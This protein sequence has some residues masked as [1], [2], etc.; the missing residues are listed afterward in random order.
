MP[1]DSVLS[2]TLGA[3][4]AVAGAIGAVAGVLGKVIF[5]RSKR[6][7]ETIHVKRLEVYPL[8]WKTTE[9]L[10]LWPRSAT[11]TCEKLQGFCENLRDWYFKVGGMFLSER[12]RN[13]YGRL[14]QELTDVLK[15]QPQE[16][17]LPTGELYERLRHRCSTLRTELTEDLSSRR[18]FS[19]TEPRPEN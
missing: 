3:V 12:S 15:S 19:G 2:S 17:L 13:A 4:G 7:D 6:A 18:R 9:I 5:D 10:P 16:P 8:L 11:V 14:Q 1:D